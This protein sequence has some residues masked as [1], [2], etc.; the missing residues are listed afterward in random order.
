MKNRFKSCSIVLALTIVLASVTGYAAESV[1]SSIELGRGTNEFRFQGQSIHNSD[2]LKALSNETITPQSDVNMEMS[3]E[4][5]LTDHIQVGA[6]LNV[7]ASPT[8]DVLGFMANTQYR[9]ASVTNARVDVGLRRLHCGATAGLGHSFVETDD[10]LIAGAGFPT[11]VSLGKYFAFTSGRS[12]PDGYLDDIITMDQNDCNAVFIFGVPVGA[13]LSLGDSVTFGVR[14]GFK[15]LI[16][17][18]ALGTNFVP[19]AVDVALAVGPTIDVGATAEWPGILG[20]PGFT[21]KHENY[22]FEQKVSAWTQVRF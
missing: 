5:G 9:L 14:T 10:A 19:L 7:Q 20:S 17:G 21:D 8:A 6:Y 4:R 2:A 22:L 18:D 12:T 1:N 15:A 3:L 13:M 11:K 16:G